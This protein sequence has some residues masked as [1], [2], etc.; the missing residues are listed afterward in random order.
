MQIVVWRPPA[1]L[2]GAYM[3][4]ATGGTYESPAAGGLCGAAGA[5]SV[6]RLNSTTKRCQ[7]FRCLKGVS[8]S[9]LRA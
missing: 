8:D 2:K 7:M 4:K 1:T 6:G 9:Y 3:P 5:V